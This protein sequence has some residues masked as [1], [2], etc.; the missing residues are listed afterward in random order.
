MA[1][2]ILSS[3]GLLA[4]PGEREIERARRITSTHDKIV[5]NQVNPIGQE[6]ILYR[7]RF[8]L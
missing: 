6:V 3:H 4:K 1:A 8:P 2:L 7:M 5:W